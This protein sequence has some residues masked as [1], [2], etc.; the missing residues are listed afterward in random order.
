M[1]LKVRKDGAWVTIADQ[2][3]KGTKGNKGNLGTKGEKN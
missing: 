2:G 3:I 1:T